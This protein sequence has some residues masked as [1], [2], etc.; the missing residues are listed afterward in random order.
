MLVPR[1][2]EGAE[3]AAVVVSVVVG[4]VIGV[5][6]IGFLYSMWASWRER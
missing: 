6:A 4:V 1:V 5:A 2:Q 3:P